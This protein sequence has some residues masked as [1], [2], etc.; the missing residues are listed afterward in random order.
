MSINNTPQPCAGAPFWRGWCYTHITLYVLRSEHNFGYCSLS[1]EEPL[2]FFLFLLLLLPPPFSLPL[3]FF[4]KRLTDLELA[5]QATLVGQLPP[6]P[7]PMRRGGCA[8][9]KQPQS[10]VYKNILACQ[11]FFFGYHFI[12]TYSLSKFLVGDCPKV[13]WDNRINFLNYCFLLTVP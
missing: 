6:A 13:G 7:H 1:T 3:L 10:L 2:L 11:G 9:L 4:K 8:C 12:Y 5:K